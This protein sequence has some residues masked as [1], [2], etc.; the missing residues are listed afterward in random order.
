M[1]VTPP[2]SAPPAPT[3]PLPVAA[4][5]GLA[6]AALASGVSLRLADALLPRLVHDFDVSLG[7]A[8]LVITVF[9]VA[10]GLS[11][12][13]FGPLGDRFGKYRVI[14][15][16]CAASALTSLACGLAPGFGALLAARLAAGASAAAVIPLAMAWIGDVVP[17]AQR[18]PVLARFL[19]GQ[20]SGFALGVW[21][22][23]FAAEHLD[24][25]APF[26]GV[27]GLFALMALVLRQLRQRLPAS[28]VQPGA[29]GG[30]LLATLR[31]E[32]G[33][34]L[35]RPW[36]RVVVATVAAEGAALY[37]PFAFI[38]AHLHHRFALPLS[39]VGGLV[40]G[41]A[42]GGLVFALGARAL[43]ARL[44]EV[45]LVRVGSWLMAGA[46]A[47]V[48]LA[49]AWGWSI[50]ACMVMGLGFY[51]MHN[52]LQ[53]NATQMAPERRGAAVA[54]FAA[55]FFLGQS[56]GVAMAGAVVGRLGTTW[57]IGG[58]ALGV[59]AVAESFNRQRRRHTA[60]AAAPA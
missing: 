6:L 20:I 31:R 15:W 16:A 28:A 36:A 29:P 2:P 27:A 51:M 45:V 35:S 54:T 52:T 58:G 3:A 11:Q 41:Y 39:T 47:T 48:A 60:L 46:L 19:I 18:Q 22:G 49:P 59:L 56:A 12:L 50:P 14:G 57:V 21:L 4:I 26:L 38:A 40:L 23:G 55:C 8:S 34:V 24:W 43:V 25:R 5:A 30:P 44:G 13:V 7:Q 17:F 53:T 37:G 9:A 33:A 10:Y 32:F 1:P 42:L